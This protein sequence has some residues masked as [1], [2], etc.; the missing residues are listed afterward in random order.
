MADIVA[1]NDRLNRLIAEAEHL[2]R[3]WYR[4]QAEAL[5]EADDR[6]ARLVELRM[7][8][9]DLQVQ[10]AQARYQAALAAYRAG[11]VSP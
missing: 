4:A 9:K 7:Q 3:Q 5:N 11:S 2:Y 8:A 1:L 10:E 6:R